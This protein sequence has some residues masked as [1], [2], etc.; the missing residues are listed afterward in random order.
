MQILL[1]D[2]NSLFFIHCQKSKCFSVH[3]GMNHHFSRIGMFE[4]SSF[5]FC[6]S[7]MSIRNDGGFSSMNQHVYDLTRKEKSEFHCISIAMSLNGLY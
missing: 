3:Q 2:T 1:T 7:I 5:S 6:Q 4:K